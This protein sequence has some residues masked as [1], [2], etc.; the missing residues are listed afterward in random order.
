MPKSLSK[1]KSSS[2]RDE[3]AIPRV[4]ARQFEKPFFPYAHCSCDLADPKAFPPEWFED[5]YHENGVISNHLQDCPQLGFL[6]PKAN[7]KREDPDP[8]G[9]Y[10][11][12]TEKD[13]RPKAGMQR[14][15]QEASR[16]ERKEARRLQ[17]AKAK[18]EAIKD[19]K[20]AFSPYA[21]CHCDDAIRDS[22]ADAVRD[23]ARI[24]CF[25]HT[26]GEV[27]FHVP[28][29]PTRRSDY[30]LPRKLDASPPK[31]VPYIDLEERED[32]QGVR[33]KSEIT[34]R[35]PK[36][37]AYIDLEEEE[38]RKEARPAS[39]AAKRYDPRTI[40]SDFLR[41]IGRHPTLPS[42]NAHMEKLP[43][44]TRSRASLQSQL[45]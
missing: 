4:E 25:T 6:I 3:V 10:L 43:S 42:L 26:N 9:T 16:H 28:R 23:L 21:H 37:E 2:R 5:L 8:L 35:Q 40:A 1:L 39:P 24:I 36:S 30:T 12:L 34:R 29:C 19:A 27:S 22:E 31:P 38:E 18:A 14:R 17:A 33:K 44:T 7:G 15:I 20:P 41:V 13:Q 32:I 45:D 11:A